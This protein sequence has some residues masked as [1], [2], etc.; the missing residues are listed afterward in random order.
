MARQP[1]RRPNICPF[2]SHSETC[3]DWC[4][5]CGDWCELYRPNEKTYCGLLS[6]QDKIVELLE[7]LQQ[8][9]RY[10][11]TGGPR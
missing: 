7:S 8:H 10:E 1:N 6:C 4:E 5:T 2:D 9:S 11:S 3:G